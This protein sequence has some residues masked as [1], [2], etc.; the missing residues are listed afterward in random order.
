MR[1]FLSEWRSM[2]LRSL[3]VVVCLWGILA[4]QTDSEVAGKKWFEAGNSI[5]PLGFGISTPR[6]DRKKTTNQKENRKTNP[7][8]ATPCC[9]LPG[10]QSRIPPPPK[11]R[12]S[13]TL[14]GHYL[15][16][17]DPISWDTPYSVKPRRHQ[18]PT[19][20]AQP[21]GVRGPFFFGRAIV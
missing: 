5:L 19:P 18:I 1:N 15:V 4:V 14:V 6:R 21:C 20:L 2:Q 7:W 10:C 3:V 8:A 9:C 13:S 16:N 12:E 11:N 17:Y